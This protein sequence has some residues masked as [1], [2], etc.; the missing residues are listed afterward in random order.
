M[1]QIAVFD[2]GDTL[3]PSHRKINQVIQEVVGDAPEIDINKYNVY[4]PEQMNQWLE[5]N[6]IEASGEEITNEYLEW[7]T[8]YLKSKVIPKLKEINREY[9][10]IG[11]IS[12]NSVP[13]K[14]FYAENFRSEGL[15]YE[16]F[17]VS[18]EVG[19]EKPDSKIFETFVEQREETPEQMTYFG[20]YVD[21]DKAAEKVGMNFVWVKQHYTFGSSTEGPQ[22]DKINYRNVSEALKRV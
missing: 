3:V 19:V 22:I 18:S 5:E 14:K 1:S 20:N 4:V 2:I 6:G 17:V 13:A 9:G 16:G 12:D 15:E 7:K 21:R 8:Q 10:P 11:F